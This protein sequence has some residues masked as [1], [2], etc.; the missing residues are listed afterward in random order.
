[1]DF[2][3]KKNYYLLS[4]EGTYFLLTLLFNYKHLYL[5][6]YLWARPI[7]MFYQHQ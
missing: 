7:K 6:E 5:Y 3:I 1:M 4:K 2:K